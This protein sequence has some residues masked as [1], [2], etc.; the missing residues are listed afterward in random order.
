MTAVAFSPPGYDPHLTQAV[1]R[2]LWRPQTI[3]D[4]SRGTGL[5]YTPV[6]MALTRLQLAGLARRRWV[7]GERTYRWIWEAV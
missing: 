3:L 5:G 1:L 6:K 7:R 4:I 2:H